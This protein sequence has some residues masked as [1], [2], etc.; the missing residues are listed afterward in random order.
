MMEFY[1]RQHPFIESTQIDL[2]LD[3]IIERVETTLS[4]SVYT[5]LILLSKLLVGL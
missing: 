5:I 1:T 3:H 2:G 4:A